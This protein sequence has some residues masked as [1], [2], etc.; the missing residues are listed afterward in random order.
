V[1]TT[2]AAVLQTL[3]RDVP[4]DMPVTYKLATDLF[5]EQ[6][7]SSELETAL[8]DVSSHLKRVVLLTGV[9]PTS[10]ADLEY[11]R[12]EGYLRCIHSHLTAAAKRL[13]TFIAPS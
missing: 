10:D 6:R 4:P 7:A 2:S 5:E 13:G 1:N 3:L 12:T 9:V 8:R 11:G